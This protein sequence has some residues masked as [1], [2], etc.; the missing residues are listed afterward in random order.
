MFILLLKNISDNII[1]QL[2]IISQVFEVDNHKKFT[3]VTWT[4][5]T[6]NK[7]KYIVNF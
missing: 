5:K 7:H 1:F 2:G 4:D 6:F 3:Y